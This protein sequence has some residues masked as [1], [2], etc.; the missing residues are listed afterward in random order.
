MKKTKKILFWTGLVVLI[1]SIVLSKPL[2][3]Y[4]EIWNFNIARCIS[5]GLV[6]Y[7]DISMI[8]TPLAGCIE[9]IFLKI[10]GSEMIV[11]RILAIALM[12]GSYFIIHK[13]FIKLN[14]REELSYLFVLCLVLLNQSSIFMDY[15]YMLLML[16]LILLFM[17]L[18]YKGKRSRRIQIALGII[19]GLCICTKQTIGLLICFAL[20]LNR[21]LFVKN[22]SDFKIELTTML[23]RFIGILIPSAI[24]VLYMLITKSFGAFWD[25]CVLGISTFSNRITYTSLIES[26]K[27][28]AWLAII[29]PLTLIGNLV[30]VVYCKIKNKEFSN[31]F[32]VLFYSIPMFLFA[33]PIFD[34]FHMYIASILSLILLGNDLSFLFKFLGKKLSFNTNK[35]IAEMTG[36]VAVLVMVL[37]TANTEVNTMEVL[38]EL[39]KYKQLNHFKYIFVDNELNDMIMKTDE[40]M[41]KQEKAVYILDPNSAMYMIPSNRYTKDYDLFM[42]GNFGKGGEDKLIERIKNEEAQYLILSD[43]YALNWQT[44]M[45][46]R[47]YVKENMKRIGN[48]GQLDVYENEV[49]N[50]EVKENTD[51]SKVEE[52]EENKE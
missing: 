10:F 52:N 43:D 39:S 19:G 14:V 5:N 12:A 31:I 21:L 8:V 38:S 1:T 16:S 49:Q 42:L 44:P 7:R 37:Y 17:D 35:F 32:I 30:Y 26:Q 2:E 50:E 45:K 28:G 9:A 20:V 40:Y 47:E 41:A 4:D 34:E 6:P 15:N 18:K 3:N 13:I 23:F 48:V 27:I 24:F 29:V 25:Y 11:A 51:E 46:V 36:I 33:Y 22:K